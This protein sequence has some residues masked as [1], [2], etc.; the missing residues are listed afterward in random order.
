MPGRSCRRAGPRPSA[1]RRR[2]VPPPTRAAIDCQESS[3]RPCSCPSR[4]GCRRRQPTRCTRRR[5][6][7]RT[8][9]SGE[10]AAEEDEAEDNHR[11]DEDDS[12]IDGGHG[13][14]YNERFRVQG[15]WTDFEYCRQIRKSSSSAPRNMAEGFGRFLP[16]DFARFMRIALGSL[17][18]TRD[19]LRAGDEQG[20]LNT[21]EYQELRTLADRAI[22]A[23]VRLTDYLEGAKKTWPRRHLRERSTRRRHSREP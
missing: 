11:L 19:H 16:G 10:V 22:G 5:S 17:N 2:R 20:Y 18:E 14:E 13:T 8:R 3:L 4:G 15:S 21:T 1:S 9:A 12:D 23:S 6:P 7:S